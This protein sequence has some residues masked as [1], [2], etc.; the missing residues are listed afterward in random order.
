MA[1]INVV[2][3]TAPPFVPGADNTAALAKIDNREALLRSVELFLN[4]DEIRHVQLVVASDLLEE[5]KRKH[6][7]HLGFSGVKVSGA[8]GKFGDQVAKAAEGLSPECTHIL[9]HDAARPAV[10]YTDIDALIA[11]AASK[12]AINC[13]SIP[14]RNG[15]VQLDE[16]GTPVG[17]ETPSGFA[18][19]VMPMLITK[20]KFLELAKAKREPHAS[21]LTLLKGSP[22]N[23]RLSGGGDAGML[24][25]MISMLPKPKTKGPA[26]PFDEAQ[27]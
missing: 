20:A 9:L 8:A 1:D 5:V 16:G 10:P 13:L 6:G 4:R 19:L 17:L 18:Q 2:L 23:V 12:P 3:V 21:E 25:A 11:A 15:I 22:L 24:R 7:A 14:M 27:W 26:S